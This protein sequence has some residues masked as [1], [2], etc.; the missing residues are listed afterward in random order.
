[1]D[2]RR[3]RAGALILAAGAAAGAMAP[4]AFPLRE[5]RW[6]AP[7]A[8]PHSLSYEPPECLR[9]PSSRAETRMSCATCHRNGRGNPDFVFPGLSGAPG[10]A[11]VTASLMSSHRGD[12]LFNPKPIPDLAGPPARL[13]ISRTVPGA[14]EAFIHGLVTKEFDGP[15]P[16]P[17][18]LADLA[19]YVR[20]L[21]PGACKGGDRP[22][23]LTDRLADVDGAV[24]LARTSDGDTRRLLLAA[25]RSTLG[26]ID[27]RFAGLDRGRAALRDADAELSA[28]RLERTGFATWDAKWPGRRRLLIRDEP[29][30]LYT[31]AKLAAAL[32]TR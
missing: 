17:E 28:I 8:L 14:L 16:P 20:A 1:M 11:D 15:E 7:S 10:T 25:A 27:E 4:L 18:V 32:N 5:A 9:P 30:S 3:A 2:R 13:K 21:Q 24:A 23:R 26:A 19:A 29:L 22:I 31:A 6:T 12:G